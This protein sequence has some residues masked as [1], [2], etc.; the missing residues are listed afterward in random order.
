ML[1]SSGKALIPC[2]GNTYTRL[3]ERTLRACE[4]QNSWVASPGDTGSSSKRAPKSLLTPVAA[5]R[6]HPGSQPERTRKPGAETAQSHP[7]SKK[8]N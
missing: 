2:V 1:Q 3:D 8:A 7:R 5:A 4:S 6:A